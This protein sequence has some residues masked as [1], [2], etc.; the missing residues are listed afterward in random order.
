MPPRGQS[1]AHLG[2]G[3]PLS[4]WVFRPRTTRAERPILAVAVAAPRSSRASLSAAEARRLALAAQGFGR[5]RPESEPDGWALRRVLADVGL[6]QIDS[7]NV[8]VRA[9]YLP[10]F[11]RL[12]PY[13][14]ELLDELAYAGRRRRLFEYWGH[15]ASLIPV[16]SQPLLRWRM[17]RAAAGQEIYGRVARVLRPR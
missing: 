15:E 2:A 13:R 11:S 14:R 5:S 9:H 17:E 6:L 3:L 12:G 4:C 1:P 7:V 8:L 16:T 10:L